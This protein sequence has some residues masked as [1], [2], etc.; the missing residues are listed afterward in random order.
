MPETPSNDVL[1]DE[2]A[3]RRRRRIWP[4]VLGFFGL[5]V[6]VLVAAGI[7]GARLFSEA[8]DVR[9]DLE[10]AKSRLGNVTEL[11]R[12][13]DAEQFS[14][15]AADVLTYTS[16]ADRIVQGPLWQYASW[17]PFVGQNVAAIRDTTEATHI[18]VRDALPA[19]FTVL[20]AMQRENIRFEGG[21]F[22]LATFRGALDALPAVDAAFTEASVKISDIDRDALLP[23][24]DDA[25]GQVIDVIEQSAPIAHTATEVLPTAL[26]M[27]GE[28]GPRT[29]LVIFQNNA[30]IRATGGEGAAAVYVRADGGRITLEGLTGSTTFESP[31]LSGVQHVE[32]PADTLALYDD[33]FARFSQNYTKTPNFPTAAK[34]FQ[35]IAAKT[36]FAVD[37]VLSLDP[38]V[39]ADILSVTGPVTVDGIEI[40]ADNAVQVLLSDTYLRFPGDQAPA[41]AFFAATS[42]TVFQKLVG[43]DWNL[44]AMLDVF[45]AAG[46]QQRLYGWFTR[47]EEEV[48]AQELGIDG[49]MTSDNIDTTEV[50]IFLNDAAVSK[51]EYYL[52]TSIAVTC[53]ATNRTVTTAITMTNSVDRDDLTFHIL[54]RRS[55]TYGGSGTS[56]LLDVLYFAP[57]GASITSVSPASGDA[58]GLDR[59][60]TEDGRNAQSIAILLDRGQTRT[61]SYTS[62]LPEGPLGPLSVRYSPTVTDT[63][64]TIDQGCAAL[65]P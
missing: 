34:L 44:M 25:V 5:I 42:A 60:S 24:V 41:D 56:M 26:K 19:S 29:Y 28:D 7:L 8:M 46:E 3:P 35:G 30:E 23:F 20:G 50:G 15:V 37:G 65:T 2:P 45:G 53:D 52:S 21:G 63:P 27:L 51:L 13:G 6:I 12:S 10:A 16:D 31:G 43:G 47:P 59:A 38:V 58:E 57:P 61:V 4:W 32:L 1:I 55:P 64:I 36:G 39:L 40:T 54:A 33:E 9:D 18:L 14:A 17:V 48:V 49:A 62:V 11:V 22:N